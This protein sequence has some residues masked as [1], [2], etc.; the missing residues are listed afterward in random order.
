MIR[1]I[2]LGYNDVRC[3]S[4]ERWRRRQRPRSKG[5]AV[6]LALL[7]QNACLWQSRGSPTVVRWPLGRTNAW[8]KPRTTESFCTGTESFC[9]GT[10][11]SASWQFEPRKDTPRSSFGRT[12]AAAVVDAVTPHL[13]PRANKSASP[14]PHVLVAALAPIRLLHRRFEL[15]AI[16]FSPHTYSIKP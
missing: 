16:T 12:A 5:Q 2:M 3:M 11:A 13:S 6:H 10:L 15:T 7:D 14:A 4:L 1:G 9:T 8:H